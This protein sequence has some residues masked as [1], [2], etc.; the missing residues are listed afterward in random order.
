MKLTKSTLR[1]IIKEELEAA[2]VEEGIMDFFKKSPAKVKKEA[3]ETLRNIESYA[4]FIDR[5]FN[6][7]MSRGGKLTPDKI[8]KLKREM[9]QD[10]AGFNENIYQFRALI[11]DLEERGE[12]VERSIPNREERIKKAKANMDRVKSNFEKQMGVR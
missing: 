11:S 1:Q 5:K 6:H 4:D 2:T 7:E 9:K 8:T 3:F 12:D 10:I